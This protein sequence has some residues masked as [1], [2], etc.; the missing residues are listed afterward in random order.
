[1]FRSREATDGAPQRVLASLGLGTQG[2][3]STTQ[4]SLGQQKLVGV[5]RALANN[6]GVLLLDEP[7]A[8]LDAT[9][10]K[11]LARHLRG[12]AERGVGMLL[13]DHDMDLIFG[14]CDRVVVLVF[15]EVIAEGTPAEVRANP[16]VVEAYL[17]TPLSEQE[18]AAVPAPALSPPGESTPDATPRIRGAR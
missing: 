13:V 11:Q 5:A 6:P 15:G 1:M 18:L 7:A 2:H 17:G 4:L 16:A 8:G 12:L 10:S 3:L 9:E 14:T